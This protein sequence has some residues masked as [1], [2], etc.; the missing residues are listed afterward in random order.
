MHPTPH[1]PHS[2]PHTP[3]PQ[4]SHHGLA[5][6]KTRDCAA[7]VSTLHTGTLESCWPTNG[8]WFLPKATGGPTRGDSTKCV[9]ATIP[10]GEPF[11]VVILSRPLPTAHQDAH[12]TSSTVT[13]TTRPL[14]LL[15]HPTHSPCSPIP[16]TYPP[17]PSH[18][19]TPHTQ[20]THS[21]L[22]PGP[23]R[24]EKAQ[25][26][27]TLLLPLKEEVAFFHLEGLQ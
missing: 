6:L 7:S 13:Y 17:H 20:A 8:A 1:T 10:E 2:T 4:T 15:T 16:P 24:T 21:P 18:P 26:L 22:A 11:T 27:L 19:L 25:V 9:E 14:T 23:A 5:L 12:A 3:H